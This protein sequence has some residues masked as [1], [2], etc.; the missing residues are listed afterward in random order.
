[1]SSCGIGVKYYG[2][3]LN[4]LLRLGLI[5]S[6]SFLFSSLFLDYDKLDVLNVIFLEAT[7]QFFLFFVADLS[8]LISCSSR[9]NL[10]VLIYFLSFPIGDLLVLIS[11][12]LFLSSLLFL[13]ESDDLNLALSFASIFNVIFRFCREEETI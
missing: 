11:S 8:L 5:I 12:I 2:L 9:F 10:Y 13:E 3:K 4:V 1:M 6:S 7:T